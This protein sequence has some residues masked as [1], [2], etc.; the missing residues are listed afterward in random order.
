M[1]QTKVAEKIKTHTLC[2]ILFFFFENRVLYEIMWK[3]IVQP[4]EPQMTM[5]RMRCACRILKATNT[6]SEY[7]ICIAFP[8]QQW[9]HERV[10]VLRYTYTAGPVVFATVWTPFFRNDA[11]SLGSRFP[12]FRDNVPVSS[13]MVE[14][15]KT[16][17][18]PM[19]LEHDIA[20]KR[21]E[22]IT[23]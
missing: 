10:S 22:P 1:F 4:D 7:V 18:T 8:L 14:T 17:I 3:S 19:K 2:S 13:A 16:D 9:L 5:W 23:Q 20:T 6:R 11:S 15:S 12:M 21:R